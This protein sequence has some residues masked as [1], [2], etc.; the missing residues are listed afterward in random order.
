MRK[1]FILAFA[2]LSLA[3]FGQKH[4]TQPQQ[5]DSL[6]MVVY[7]SFN[8]QRERIEGLYELKAQW[9]DI[10]RQCYKS[11]LAHYAKYLNESDYAV[12]MLYKLRTGVEKK[13]LASVMKKLKDKEIKATT[14]AQL[15]DKY[16]TTEQ[17]MVGGKYLDFQ[18]TTAQA[19]PFVLSELLQMKDVLLIFG[20]LGCMGDETLQL[21][22][23]CYAT[24]DISKV[25]I[26]S[27]FLNDSMKD[28]M[29]EYTQFDVRWLGV[30][31][32]LGE[33]SEV[34]LNYNVQATPTC[35]YIGSNGIVKAWSLGVTDEILELLTK[36]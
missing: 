11:M 30:C 21:L 22:K 19:Q 10:D 25:E 1:L 2:L 16:L 4:I 9:L 29:D 7:Y 27:V 14:Y 5:M 8:T 20:G 33:V 12:S 23:L 35:V 18:A 6:A 28:F 26:V 17:V 34:K 31:D 15:I 24:L 32:M 3:S 36:K 13:D